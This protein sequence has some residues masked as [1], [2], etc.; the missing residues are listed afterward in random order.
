LSQPI[1]APGAERVRR[2]NMTAFLQRVRQRR[3]A[4]AEAVSDFASLYR[5][6]VERPEA[7]WPEVWEF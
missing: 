1:W 5:W 3:P 2:A 6:S 4:G 7:F